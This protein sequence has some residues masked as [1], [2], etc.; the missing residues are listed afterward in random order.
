MVHSTSHDGPPSSPH[1]YTTDGTSC[2]RIHHGGVSDGDG[3]LH[4]GGRYRGM[5]LTPLVAPS[6]VLHPLHD[7]M[8][9][10]MSGSLMPRSMVH[11]PRIPG[12]RYPRIREVSGWSSYWPLPGT[13]LMVPLI[14]GHPHTMGYVTPVSE[15]M[16]CYPTYA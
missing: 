11:D 12:S 3:T 14:T 8:D 10:G 4:D 2:S 1:R 5:V 7:T 9:P 16:G 15:G 13:P 6:M